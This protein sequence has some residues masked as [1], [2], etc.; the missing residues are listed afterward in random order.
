MKQVKDLRLPIAV[1]YLC[2][3]LRK[4][5]IIPAKS[6]YKSKEFS[7]S[8][9]TVTASGS[10]M[11][12]NISHPWPEWV[13]L[14][15]ILLRERYFEGIGDPF[16]TEVLGPKESNF[17]RTACLNF[18]RDQSQIM[19]NLSSKDIRV[20]VEC[21]CPS[22]D[23]KVVNSGKR[24][25][26]Y[27]GLDEGKTCSLC[28]LRGNCERAFVEAGEGEHGRTVDVMRIL[29]TYGLDPIF[30][31]MENKSCLNIRAKASVR[32]LL[33][34][35]VECSS[36]FPVSNLSKP[37]KAEDQSVLPNSLEEDYTENKM[38]PGDWHC[39][40]CNF[41]NFSRN[42]KCLRCGSL[43]E[44]KVRQMQEELGHLPL[45]KGDW[46]CDKCSILNFAKN[47]RCWKCHAKPPKR[48]LNPGE[49]ECE[50]CNYINFRRN[51]ICLNCDYKRPK[52]QHASEFSVLSEYGKET[53]VAG[54]NLDSPYYTFGG[55]GP[56]MK[57]WS[58][59]DA[60]GE[61]EVREQLNTEDDGA[62]TFMDF[63]ISGGKS[64]LS[65]DPQRIE[66]WKSKIAGMKKRGTE[67]PE[68]RDG[69]KPWGTP[70][71]KTETPKC[72]YEED[73][74][75]ADWFGVSGKR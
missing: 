65:R 50:S 20:I 63:P 24:I 8:K 11:K 53:H 73:D 35:I 2:G 6:A 60:D 59:V 9:S 29:L 1:S 62:S 33:K 7:C 13:G 37:K 25:R 57:E 49:W 21:G 69:L 30:S 27:I 75:M 71:K 4:A 31:T 54:E 38:K 74:D 23:R 48:Q 40:K 51:A 42:I 14:M 44:E 47:T 64:D 67:R 55:Q 52:A 46:I 3:R 10:P 16:Q 28:N 34:Q 61:A 18:G 68:R 58:F 43:N 36:K 45:K 56:C 66:E 17:I 70:T 12:L 39:F 22:T 15:E 41:M 19:G 72:A 32:N 5:H 26:A